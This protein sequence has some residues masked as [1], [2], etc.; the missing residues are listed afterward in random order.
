LVSDVR[1]TDGSTAAGANIPVAAEVSKVVI[2]A[3]YPRLVAVGDAARARAQSA[4]AIASAVTGVLAVAVITTKAELAGQAVR[5]AGLLALALWLL[6]AASYVRAVATPVNVPENSTL[7]SAGDLAVAVI[8]GAKRERGEVDRRQRCA[9]LL[10]LVAMLTTVFAFAALLFWPA[11]ASQPQGT[12]RLTAE[13]LEAVQAICP[14]AARALSGQVVRS[15]I[16]T[17]FI[18]VDVSGKICGGKPVQIQVPK[19]QVEAIILSR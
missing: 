5:W 14:G 7:S 1:G 8:D 3:Y 16:G 2:E 17:E 4:Y 18:S 10:A 9:N 12:L 13:G 19:A 11:E 6:A 15:S